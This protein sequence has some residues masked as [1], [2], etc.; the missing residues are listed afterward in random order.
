M[1]S[2]PKPSLVT[3]YTTNYGPVLEYSAHAWQYYLTSNM[4]GQLEYNKEVSMLV[5][6]W[7]AIQQLHISTLNTQPLPTD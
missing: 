3:I 6:P 5:Y 4:T 1:G 7:T 2:I